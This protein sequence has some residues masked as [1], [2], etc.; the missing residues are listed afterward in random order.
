MKHLPV[1]AM[2]LVAACAP[3]ADADGVVLER[4][5]WQMSTTFGTPKVDGLSIDRLRDQLP[6]DK[7]ETKCY[8][9][10]VRSGQRFM[11]LVNLRHDVCRIT[12][13]ST[14]DG[15][16]SAEETCPGIAAAVAS[17][18]SD[19]WMKVNGTYTPQYIDAMIEVV[20]TATE[21][22]GVTQRMTISGRHKAER[23]GECS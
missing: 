17:E 7:S 14:T 3:D 16:L 12:T 5:M 19:S 9:P 11:E 1:A 8:Q 21:Q 4:G 13:A 15:Q 23:I 18:Q 10:V 2:V 22:S 6:P 20:V